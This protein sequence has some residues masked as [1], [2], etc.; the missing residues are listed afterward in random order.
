MKKIYSLLIAFVAIFCSATAVNAQFSIT[1]IV[2]DATRVKVTVD[3]V[4]ATISNGSNTVTSDAQYPSIEI[5]AAS[6]E[7]GLS[8][9]IQTTTS[10]ISSDVYIDNSSGT[11]ICRISGNN[12]NNGYTYTVTSFAYAEARTAK[13][14]VNVDDASKVILYR[15]NNQVTLK[16]GDN[17][18]AFIP[19]TEKTFTIRPASGNYFYQVLQNGTAQTADAEGQYQLTIADGDKILIKATWPNKNVAVRFVAANAGTESFITSVYVDN[20]PVTNYADANF[21]VKLGS[22]LSWETNITDFKVN[23]IKINNAVTTE[24]SV[25]VATESG[26]TITYDVARWAILTITVDIDRANRIS[27]Y[28]YVNYDQTEITGLKDGKNTIEIAENC[29]LTFSAKSSCRVESFTDNDGND[30]TD[31]PRQSMYIP[32]KEGRIFTIKTWGLDRD[33]QFIFY[34]DDPSKCQY[35]GY[36]ILGINSENRWTFNFKNDDGTY[37]E[38]GYHTIAFNPIDDNPIRLGMSG[39]SNPICYQQDAIVSGLY[40][41]YELTVAEGDVVKVFVAG[42]PDKY[43]VTFE[44]A[45]GCV[46]SNVVRDIIVPVADVTSPLSVL[47]GTQI[48]F[49]QTGAVAV[50]VNGAALTADKDGVYTVSITENTK[51]V[52]SDGSS[53]ALDYTAAAMNNDVYTLQGILLIQDATDAQIQA[54]PAG[55]Y[56]I[57]GKTTYLLQR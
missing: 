56:I 10:N 15:A 24:Q 13:C 14:T 38:S 54:L 44:A 17:A 8:Q 36:L 53:T 48:S 25:L 50:L 29:S 37:I 21:S 22:T 23:S 51:I 43:N 28:K 35:G 6:T 16:N 11:S 26:L 20:V 42:T 57:N 55:L 31:Y 18:V 39:V 47:E 7:Y 19:D 4:D 32:V 30:Y 9:V 34:M 46:F 49:K 12:Y 52:A 5:A 45:K 27:L 2:D 33:S 41:S 40:G 3:G 1:V